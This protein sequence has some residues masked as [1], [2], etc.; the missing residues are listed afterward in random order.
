[1]KV[2]LV[3]VFLGAGLATLSAD[4]P[5]ALPGPAFSGDRYT[6][7]W[8]KSPFAIATPDAPATSSEYEFVALAQLEGVTYVTLIDKQSP[9]QDHFVLSSDKPVRNLTLVSA[10]RTA[11]GTSAVVEHNGERLTLQLEQAA[12]PPPVP[13]PAMA[14]ATGIPMTSSHPFMIP[15]SNPSVGGMVPAPPHARFHFRTRVPLPPPA[16]Q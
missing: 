7:L 5:G 12:A 13:L 9:G 6:A 4:E 2:L 14:G 10:T 3:A 15:S 11:G 1:M 16:T 8:S